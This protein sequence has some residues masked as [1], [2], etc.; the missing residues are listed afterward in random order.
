VKELAPGT[1][2]GHYKIVRRLGQGGMGVV[3]E[4]VDQKLGRHVAVK[5]LTNA[6]DAPGRDSDP[7]LE[8]FWRE[9]RAAS[10]LNHPGICIIHELDETASPPFL[11]LELL[12]GSSLEK[13]YRG[14][15]MPYPK[16][17]AMGIQLA[18]ALDAAH[19][20]GILHRDIKPANI[21][22]TNSGQAK[23]LDFGL[24]KL[25][26][27]SVGS[28]ASTA[29]IQLTDSDSTVGT[30]AYMS[31]EQ[32]R[33]DPLDLRSDLFSLGVVLY[34]MATGQHPFSGSTTAVVFD[35]ILNHPPPPPIS[36]NAELPA[37]F[38]NILDKTL[39]KD[40]ELRCQSAAEL[41]ADL[42]RLQRK[43]SSGSVAIPAV[44]ATSPLATSS[45]QIQTLQKPQESNAGSIA[46][47]AV[48]QRRRATF[49]LAV[50][51]VLGIAGFVGWRFWPRPRPFA[52]GSVEQIT[53]IGSIEKI[54]LSAD[55]RFLAEVK[56]DKGQRT[57]WVRNTATNTETQILGASGHDYLGLT[58]SPD[59][60]H[61]YF[62]RL[63]P[64]NEIA[65][66]LY[67]MPVFGGT[68]RQL[69]FN[70]DSP[71]S[72]EPNG[73][74][75]TFLRWWPERKDGFSEIHI[76]DKDGGSDQV[77]YST[78]EKALAPVWSP[79]GRRIAWLQSEAGTVRIGLKMIEISSR[80][81]TTVAPPAGIFWVDR[82]LAYTTLAWMPDNIHLLTLYY[83]QHSDRAQIGVIT[84]P[85]GEFHS[86]TNDVNS[87]SELALSGNGRTLA[88]VLTNVDSNIALYGPDRGEPISML[89]LRI[90]P[91][92]VAWATEDR[93]LY[94]VR[95]SSI[96][97]ID[98]ATGS[99][100]SFDT[101]EVA[102]GDF[103][104]SCPDGHILFTGF[105]NGGSE[106]RLFRMK[107]DGGEIVQL[108]SSGFARSASCSVDSQK[109]YY[110]I[111]SDVNVSLW[112]IP[113][114][115]GTPKQLIPAAIYSEA[116]VSHDG[117][118]AALYAVR[119]QKV[120][121]IIADLG[122]GRMQA[123]FFIDQSLAN[124]SRFSPDGRA[125]V[126]DA[127]RSGGTTLLYQPLDGST[128]YVLFNPA[129]ET[130]N[131][132]EWSP[133]DKQLAVA[134]LKSSSDVV[135][136]IDQAGKETH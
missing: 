60:N 3:Y 54:A 88:T 35:R 73:K 30:V 10:S 49:L 47:P 123:P 133:S 70:V 80:K 85:S 37:E 91:N 83:K 24:A 130:I 58:F 99:V 117:T 77:L 12:E 104:A 61:L 71:V 41:R 44:P 108:T 25:D 82:G 51:A 126:S 74:R 100:Q 94:I 32:A 5:V 114:S 72:F 1:L 111:G 101:G 16:L 102:P 132:F 127:I 59:G 129:P 78:A 62:T 134:R 26:E 107:A 43:S 52:A 89:P 97:T 98:R 17:V 19:R 53:N 21:F 40:R 64:E 46:V 105:P 11:V 38:E 34:E 115:G 42:K 57:L 56:N 7:A 131:D 109:A 50:L 45:P 92:A 120:C 28:D 14:H 79:D 122:S 27:T 135:L 93:L 125:I 128:P 15:A 118:Q 23:L 31:P 48:G 8:R 63:S 124:L 113:V 67:V 4:A 81:L 119:Q 33:G 20:K 65:N 6:A 18:D 136:I 29:V 106:S 69:I 103:I 110:S 112:S 36:L 13:L 86:V 90:T 2:L 66:N 121:V 96:G 87:Y 39:E 55:A 76:A 22:I 116:W 68:P 95:G 84:T 75:V 9:A